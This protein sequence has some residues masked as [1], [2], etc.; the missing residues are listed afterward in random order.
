MATGSRQPGR[1]PVLEE[2]VGVEEW[3]EEGDRD[4]RLETRLTTALTWPDPSSSLLCVMSYGSIVEGGCLP[5]ELASLFHLLLSSGSQEGRG[6]G[7]LCCSEV[8]SHLLPSV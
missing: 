2:V 6:G 4:S 1:Q 5:T 3:E 7:L 8:H